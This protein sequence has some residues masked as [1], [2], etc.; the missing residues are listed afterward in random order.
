M[1]LR[2]GYLAREEPPVLRLWLMSFLEGN[3]Q[4]KARMIIESLASRAREGRKVEDSGC[5]IS[6]VVM[7]CAT[8]GPQ[9]GAGAVPSKES[10]VGR[11]RLCS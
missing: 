9:A 11:D 10:P 3:L 4:A 2:E 1:R 8:D 6:G 5:G 7:E